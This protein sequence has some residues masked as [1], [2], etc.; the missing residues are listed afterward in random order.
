[1]IAMNN[2]LQLTWLNRLFPFSSLSY[3]DVGEAM[4]CHSPAFSRMSMCIYSPFIYIYIQQYT[5][6][7]RVHIS[8]QCVNK[9]ELKPEAACN[10]LCVCTASHLSSPKLA[11]RSILRHTLHRVDVCP[12]LPQHDQV[13]SDPIELYQ[14]AI[15]TRLHGNAPNRI[16]R[17]SHPRTSLLP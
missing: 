17:S 2:V 15:W 1:M 6:H 4:L 13:I 14:A 9:L 7:C 11:V 10:A 8:M 12:C 3:Y 16:I 5:M